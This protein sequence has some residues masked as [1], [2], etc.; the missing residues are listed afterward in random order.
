MKFE[1]SQ[2]ENKAK[3]TSSRLEVVMAGGIVSNVAGIPGRPIQRFLWILGACLVTTVPLDAADPELTNNASGISLVFGVGDGSDKG[4]AYMEEYFF[5]DKQLDD[6]KV[7]YLRSDTKITMSHNAQNVAGRSDGKDTYE[8]VG[9]D[10]G[11]I[12][13]KVDGDLR[14]E[15]YPHFYPTYSEPFRFEDLN[16]GFYGSP[17]IKVVGATG[18]NGLQLNQENLTK[19]FHKGMRDSVGD[20]W[21]TLTVADDD[22]ARTKN[23]EFRCS[24]GKIWTFVVNPKTPCATWRATG[25]GQFYTTPAK[26]Y[27][28]PHIYDQTTNF[29][30]RS[31]GVSVELRDINGKNVFFRITPDPNAKDIE[32]VDAGLNH[33]TLNQGSFPGGTSYLQYYCQGNEGYVKTRKVVKDPGYPSVAEKHGDRLW[34]DAGQWNSQIG[35]KVV[36]N[37]W[38]KQWN[39]KED[40]NGHASILASYRTGGRGGFGSVALVNAI[41]A[42]ASGFN[43]ESKWH[44]GHTYAEFAKKAVLD[45]T[46]VIDPI[47]IELNTS[48]MPNSSREMIYR[49][50]NDVRPVLE[51]AAAY[52]ILIGYYRAN[53][54]HPNGISPIEDLF[55]RDQMARW[56]HMTGFEFGSYSSPVWFALDRG[57]MWDTAHKIGATMIACMMPG[58]STPY[59]G[60]SGLDGNIKT[61]DHLPFPTLTNTWFDLMLDEN[62]K[63]E[64]FPKAA[65]V[66]G[67]D[68]YMFN[69]AGVWHDRT[70]YTSSGLMG[71][72]MPIYYNLIK[73]FHP[74]R[75]LPRFDKAME[76][77]GTGT[78]YGAKTINATD[79]LP[80]FRSWYALQNAWFPEFRLKARPTM[81]ASTGGS[82]TLG[83][84]S[85]SYGVLGIIWYDH[86]LPL[87]KTEEGSQP[88][89]PPTNLRI[90][91]Q[92]K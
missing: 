27:F 49:G 34:F 5:H 84:Q 56:V 73:L 61:Y 12:K 75:S 37:W 83:D 51:T 9:L 18:D 43:F 19:Y 10:V 1:M 71:Y 24:D 46:L 44:K 88:L 22:N 92:A 48:N 50:Y 81:L 90:L 68:R 89:T 65:S 21:H 57:G 17:D 58:Y 40:M 76:A 33:V 78:L 63:L 60:T 42:R 32:Y 38:F 67:L 4:T 3:P 30:A 13:F 8:L 55:L 91:K 80:V 45:N 87:S 53:Q 23:T 62:V 74:S 54:G 70:S 52:D 16:Y 59:Y 31:G 47:G 25:D 85:Q 28:M 64:G 69:D 72:C 20:E 11:V 79:K 77:A 66:V 86:N 6:R 36:S 14:M 7:V 35:P 2:I 29:S 82:E 26:T 39:E 15:A 41:V